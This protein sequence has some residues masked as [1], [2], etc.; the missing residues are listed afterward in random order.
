[1]VRSKS[2]IITYLFLGAGVLFPTSFVLAHEGKV[3]VSIENGKRCYHSNGLPDHSTGV[4]PNSGNP[5][6]I[7]AQNVNVCVSTSPAKNATPRQHRGS[8]GIGINGV[9]FRP[10]TADFYDASSPRGFSRDPSSGWSME[11][12]NP[13]NVLGMD[14]NNAH[15]GPDGLYH[16]HGVANALVRSAGSGP[17]GYA[18]DGFE[19]H[20]AGSTQSSSYRLKTGARPSGPGGVYDG[21]YVEDFNYVAGSGTLDQC[22]GGMLNGKFVYFATETFPFL[23]RCLWGNVSTDFQQPMLQDGERRHLRN[24]ANGNT[25]R[26]SRSAESLPRNKRAGIGGPRGQRG[27]PPIQAV[28]ICSGKARNADCSFQSPR[29]NHKISGSCQI[30]PSGM[31]ACVPEGGRPRS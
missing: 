30:T 16:Y 22:N 10:G 31:S 1:M 4:F 23:P 29:R 2:N 28:E 3:S 17:I 24:G 26:S 13:A 11:G 6:A 27:G 14:S 7:S 25:N 5:N 9:Q 18:A 12:L 20:Y 8:V 21:T 19:I 15:V